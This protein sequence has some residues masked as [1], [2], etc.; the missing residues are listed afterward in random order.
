MEPG[1][2]SLVM[3]VRRIEEFV[4]KMEVRGLLRFCEVK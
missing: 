3:A 1:V 4:G 2:D